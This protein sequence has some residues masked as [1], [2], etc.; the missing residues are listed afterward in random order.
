[1]IY[2]SSAWKENLDCFRKK[3]LDASQMGKVPLAAL[4]NRPGLSLML[5]KWENYLWQPWKVELDCLRC[6]PSGKSTCGSLEK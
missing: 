3:D 5:S 4:K 2:W 6:F 1:M